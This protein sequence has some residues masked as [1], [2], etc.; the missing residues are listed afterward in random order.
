M[1]IVSWN[2]CGLGDRI[3]QAAMK[4][5]MRKYK[6]DIGLI[7]KTMLNSVSEFVVKEIRGGFH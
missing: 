7:Q 6:V 5:L 3:K 4:D 2:V 1:N